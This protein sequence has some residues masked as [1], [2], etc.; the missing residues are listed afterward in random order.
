MSF[1]SNNIFVHV[2]IVLN[3][4]VLLFGFNKVQNSHKVN[5]VL[6]LAS[7]K[8][9]RGDVAFIVINWLIVLL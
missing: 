8:D 9:I 6:T 2:F 5:F 1:E 7:S 3:S 4:F